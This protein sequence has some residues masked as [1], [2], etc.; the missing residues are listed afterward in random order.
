MSGAK[1]YIIIIM[2]IASEDFL[3]RKLFYFSRDWS[4]FSRAA[5]NFLF[6]LPIETLKSSFL[7]CPS[8][9]YDLHKFISIFF[10]FSIDFHSAKK[11]MKRL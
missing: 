1:Y 8:L 3:I 6:S 10:P 2:Q 11:M 5:N 4:L 9:F 7:P